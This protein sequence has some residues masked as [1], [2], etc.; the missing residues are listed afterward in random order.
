[1]LRC[2]EG[3]PFYD[4]QGPYTQVLLCATPRHRCNGSTLELALGCIFANIGSYVCQAGIHVAHRKGLQDRLHTACMQTLT[5]LRRRNGRA[6]ALRK[7]VM[8]WGTSDEGGQ[9]ACTTC[10][11]LGRRVSGCSVKAPA[12]RPQCR[13]PS[14]A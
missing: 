11:Q 13:P 7:S 14:L 2:Q 4:R 5:A 8:T 3:I 9:C 1:M 10:M 12:S 6:Y